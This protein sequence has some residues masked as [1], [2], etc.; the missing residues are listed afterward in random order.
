MDEQQRDVAQLILWSRALPARQQDLA[1]DNQA[2]AEPLS[3][4]EFK[5]VP[6]SVLA[7]MTSLSFDLGVARRLLKQAWVEKWLGW[8]E[9][10]GQLESDLP[11]D[12]AEIIIASTM[13]NFA[14]QSLENVDVVARSDEE[15]RQELLRD[16]KVLGVGMPHGN[17]DSCADSILLLLSYQGFV[18]ASWQTDCSKGQGT[19]CLSTTSCPTQQPALPSPAAYPYWCCSQRKRCRT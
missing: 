6:D 17:N 4:D 3:P 2:S 7:S 10:R 5:F 8:D 18:S 1:R 11:P 12:R 16:G 13:Q 14:H 9:A 19:R 15:R